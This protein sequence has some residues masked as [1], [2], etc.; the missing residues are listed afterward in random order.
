MTETP[1]ALYR[2]FDVEGQLLYVG[3]TGNL[4]VRHS[5]H[6]ARSRWM[7]FMASFT[8]ERRRSLDEVR[9]AE[10]EAIETERPLFNLRHNDTPGTAQRLLDYLGSAVRLPRLP[11]SLANEQTASVAV[12]AVRQ[13]G[14]SPKFQ[15]QEILDRLF[16]AIVRALAPP[17]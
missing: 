8:V 4:A 5:T 17:G 11:D 10:R 13:A 2:Y 7:E 15:D 1:Y 16:I 6:I 14:R 3:I 12:E 9:K